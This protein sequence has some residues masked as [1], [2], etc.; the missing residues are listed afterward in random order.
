M[1][2]WVYKGSGEGLK[3]ELVDAGHLPAHLSAGWRVTE[4][5]AKEAAQEEKETGEKVEEKSEYSEEEVTELRMKAKNAGI[6]SWHVK[7]PENLRHE[8]TELGI[9]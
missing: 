4:D 1:A 9:Q 7:R 5:E 3:K 8:L 6:G 2:V